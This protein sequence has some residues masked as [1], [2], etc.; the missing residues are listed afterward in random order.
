MQVCEI[1]PKLAQ[2]IHIEHHY[3]HRKAHCRKAYGL[4]VDGCVKGV[5]LFGTPASPPLCKGLFGPEERYNI[6]ELVRLWV[7]D[8]V[9]RNGESYLISSAIHQSPYELFVSY[10]D[11]SVGHVGYVYQATNWLYTGLSAKHNQ[12]NLGGLHSK[13]IANKFSLAQ[14]RERSD[15]SITE[16]ARKHRYVFIKAGHKRYKA[17]LKKLKYPILPYPKFAGE[18][19]RLD[20]S[21]P[22]EGVGVIPTPRSISKESGEPR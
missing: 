21:A 8:S 4:F 7:D 11:S 16:R 2:K 9:P 22:T 18:V 1:E 14:L 20:T 13:G 19:S 5:C 10:A 17:L 12:W 3:L 15:F 6:V